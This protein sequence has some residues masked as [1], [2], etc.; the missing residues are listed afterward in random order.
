MIVDGGLVKVLDFGI[1]DQSAE[2]SLVAALSEMSDPWARVKCMFDTK[3]SVPDGPAPV[4]LERLEAQICEL[5]G[6]PLQGAVLLK[7]LRAAAA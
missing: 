1:A 2:V 6:P 3:E 4:P 5:A 7:A